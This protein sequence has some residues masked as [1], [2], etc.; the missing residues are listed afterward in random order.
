MSQLGILLALQVVAI[1]AVVAVV[2]VVVVVVVVL[3][4]VLVNVAEQNVRL[5]SSNCCSIISSSI[6]ITPLVS[7]TS[8]SKHA[9]SFILMPPTIPETFL[10]HPLDN[11]CGHSMFRISFIQFLLYPE[12]FALVPLVLTAVVVVVAVELILVAYALVAA[13]VIEVVII[14]TAVVV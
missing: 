11:P 1:E 12:I 9:V 10:T 2:V 7:S 4:V 13:V 6:G 8:F 14:V 5:R 3:V